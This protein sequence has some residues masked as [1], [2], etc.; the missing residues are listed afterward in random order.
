[1]TASGMVT[2]TRYRVIADALDVRSA[3]GTQGQILGVLQR[4]DVVERLDSSGDDAWLKIQGV[5]LRGWSSRKFL[6]LVPGGPVSPLDQ[7]VDLAR[8][9]AIARYD[10]RDRG[11]AAR[12]YIP[13]MA[14][15]FARVYCKLKM[16]D[17]VAQE[18]AK[19]NTGDTSRDAL[20][21]YDGQF[22]ALGMDN[23]SSGADT[24]RHLFVLLIGLG[25]RESSGR[26]CEGRDRSANNVTA[27]TAEAG[28]FQTSYNALGAHPL[29]PTV[30]QQY[31]ANPASGFMDVFK[32]GV[33]CH[34]DDWENFGE[35]TGRE[36]QELS[37][38]CPAFAA[39]FTAVALRNTRKHWGPINNK[40]AELRLECDALLRDVQQ[41]VDTNN[42]CP[43]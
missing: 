3:P 28:L 4:D 30:F 27:D 32:N 25:M 13:G 5:A 39:E 7:I 37:K 40:A 21:W 23:D 9:S 11:R 14:L 12:G 2:G 18:I 1:M 38:I 8:G 26:Y 34:A 20:A 42:L 35:G 19:A 16:S 24:L 29:L 33:Q 6:E 43:L 41:L 15:V 31:Q 17:P 10:W 22:H 36:F